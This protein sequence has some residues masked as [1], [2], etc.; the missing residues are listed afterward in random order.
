M[1]QYKDTAADYPRGESNPI[2]VLLEQFGH[3]VLP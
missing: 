3:L 1:G 2:A